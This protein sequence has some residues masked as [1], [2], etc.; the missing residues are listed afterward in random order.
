M[1]S[2]RLKYLKIRVSLSD[3]FQIT[4][5]YKAYYFKKPFKPVMF[6]IQL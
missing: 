3:L 4:L 5:H 6:N 2:Y 1:S